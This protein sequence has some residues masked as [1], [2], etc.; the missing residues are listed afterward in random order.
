MRFGELTALRRERVDILRGRL[1][2]AETLVQIGA[3]LSFGPTKT[4]KGRR[5]VPLPR[6]VMG[7]LSSHLERYVPAPADAL[8]FTGM[9]NQPLRREW[10]RRT[11]T[12][13]VDAGRAR[14]GTGR[15]T[16]PRPETPTCRC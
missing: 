9:R 7:E 3:Q 8:V 11:W 2:V 5:T 1:Q 10:F 12:H 14:R 6:R 4:R 16:V 15:P 13:L